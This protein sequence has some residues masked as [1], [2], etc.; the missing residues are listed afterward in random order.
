[1]T[2]ETGFDPERY[3]RF[4]TQGRRSKDEEEEL[5]RIWCAPKGWEYLTVVNN[6]YVGIYYLGTAF[7]FFL[8][9]ACWRC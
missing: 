9:A 6:N 8:L 7:L 5:K 2:S 1:M 4:P 3:N